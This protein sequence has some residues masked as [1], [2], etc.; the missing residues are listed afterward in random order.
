MKKTAHRRRQHSA[1]ARHLESL[2][3]DHPARVSQLMRHYIQADDRL[4][5]GLHYGLET[6]EGAA[7][8]ATE[9]LADHIVQKSRG[10]SN[11]G[12]EWAVSL[13][14]SPEIYEPLRP[15]LEFRCQKSSGEPEPEEGL[16]DMA[17]EYADTV[18]YVRRG[19]C[20]RYLFDLYGALGNRMALNRQIALY[21]AVSEALL[22]LCAG[23]VREMQDQ[24]YLAT[25]YEHLAGMEMDREDYDAAWEYHLQGL[26]IRRI[27][28]RSRPDEPIYRWALA[29]SYYTGAVIKLSRNNCTSSIMQC[30]VGLEISKLL[31]D[32]EPGEKRNYALYLALWMNM[33]L[34]R[35]EETDD[36]GVERPEEMPLEYTLDLR[37]IYHLRMERESRLG[38]QAEAERWSAML[39]QTDLARARLQIKA[40]RQLQKGLAGLAGW[41]RRTIAERS[42][43]LLEESLE[44]CRE[45]LAVAR[46]LRDANT[47]DHD[48][49]LQQWRLY[50]LYLRMLAASGRNGRLRYALRHE[51]PGL[52]KV[53]LYIQDGVLNYLGLEPLHDAPVRD[54]K[55]G[56]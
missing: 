35:H 26:E 43:E 12:I 47:G 48:I 53:L 37:L 44:H 42:R 45:S 50:F 1:L 30:Q 15:V 54:K 51:R 5:A 4:R 52:K 34:S 2:A 36:D 19:L 17:D 3:E 8:A 7:A 13:I 31:M 10:F 23:D 27:L 49:G 29:D 14:C 24:R 46:R 11:A 38:N 20:Q 22:D 16:T 33:L 55:P 40:T 32:E 41:N 18:R 28:A 56:G 21:K 39:V 25:S 9:A 6:G